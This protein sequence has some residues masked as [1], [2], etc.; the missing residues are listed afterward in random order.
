[1]NR[2]L[3]LVGEKRGCLNPLGIGEGFEQQMV[4]LMT[5][6]YRLNPLGIGEGFELI[7]DVD[8]IIEEES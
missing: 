6:V 7:G 1:M 5:L 4:S 3:L 8:S 2:P